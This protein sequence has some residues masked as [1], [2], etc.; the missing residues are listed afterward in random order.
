MDL[1][2]LD[3]LCHQKLLRRGGCS[4]AEVGDAALQLCGMHMG[5]CI[6]GVSLTAN[7]L[8]TSMME[9]GR[10]EIE[11]YL[12]FGATG[13]QSVGRLVKGAVATGATGCP[14]PA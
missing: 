9:G 7:N 4:N 11:L 5:N 3:G 10:R 1:G 12:S 8:S 14:S 2:R 6:N 13:W